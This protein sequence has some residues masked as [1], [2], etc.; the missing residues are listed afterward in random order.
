[1]IKY[2]RIIA[3]L[4][5]LISAAF[6]NKSGSGGEDP[7]P[8]DTTG[9]GFAKG[10]D[11]SWVTEMEAAGRKFYNSAGTDME[12]MALMKSLGMNTIRLRVWV[13]PSPTWN[14][15]ADV[16]AKAIRAK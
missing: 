10:A 4:V 6:C 7:V 11:I 2:I 1:M 8:T 5:I 15:T 13:D 16:V 9:T 12:C 14:N 3:P